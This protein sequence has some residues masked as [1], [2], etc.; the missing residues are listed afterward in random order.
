MDQNNPAEQAVGF[1]G[2]LKG[3]IKDLWSKYGLLFIIVG[4]ALLVMKSSNFI[5]D[6]IA[7]ISKKD[8]Q[9]AEKQDAKLK[10]EEDSAKTQADALVKQAEDLPS[11]EKPVDENWNKK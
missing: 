6:L 1:F 3:Q 5:M 9:K 2:N 11:Q 10:N 8:V 4:V 7:S